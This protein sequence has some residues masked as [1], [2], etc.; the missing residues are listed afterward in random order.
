MSRNT[1]E[2][3]IL[4]GMYLI[5]CSLLLATQRRRKTPQSLNFTLCFKHLK[6]N[7][8]AILLFVDFFSFNSYSIT[9]YF[10]HPIKHVL[11]QDTGSQSK[12]KCSFLARFIYLYKSK[13]KTNKILY[14]MQKIMVTSVL[15]QA[16]VHS[17]WAF[18]SYKYLIWL[19]LKAL[20]FIIVVH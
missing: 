14:F 6:G 2:V 15:A 7:G 12:W 20:E 4:Q 18:C 3:R 19:N 17:D 1:G 16:W 5:S 8:F 11:K 13:V 9:S 10:N